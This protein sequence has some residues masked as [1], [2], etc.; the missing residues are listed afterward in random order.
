MG[1]EKKRDVE[2]ARGQ[3]FFEKFSSS[4]E[5]HACKEIS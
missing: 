2:D 3:G 1:M 4:R 5:V